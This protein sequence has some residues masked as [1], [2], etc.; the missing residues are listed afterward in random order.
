M[1]CFSQITPRKSKHIFPVCSLRILSSLF[2]TNKTLVPVL[3]LDLGINSDPDFISSTCRTNP[4]TRPS[5]SWKRLPNWEEEI[6]SRRPWEKSDRRMDADEWDGR[7][8]RLI[9]DGRRLSGFPRC[10]F[11]VLLYV[12]FVTLYFF[13]LLMS[14]VF[15]SY[16]FIH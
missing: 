15:I 9:V 6:S 14:S 3:T 5:P 2:S 8:V 16:V 12:S 11:Y 10:H 1:Y 4:V 13:H 7:S